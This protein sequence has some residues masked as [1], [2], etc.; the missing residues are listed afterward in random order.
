MINQESCTAETDI[1]P[2]QHAAHCL[3]VDSL[4]MSVQPRRS[5]LF[6]QHGNLLLLE[7]AS[8]GKRLLPLT[9]IAAPAALVDGFCNQSFRHSGHQESWKK[10]LQQPGTDSSILDLG[11][12]TRDIIR[13]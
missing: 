13:A 5:E 7:F 4:S 6:T 9:C 12:Q 3:P 10:F 2:N 8:I 11:N 1:P